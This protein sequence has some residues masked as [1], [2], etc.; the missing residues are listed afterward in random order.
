MEYTEAYLYTLIGKP[1]SV[2]NE[3]RRAIWISVDAG[4]KMFTISGFVD[5]TI[6]DVLNEFRLVE[7]DGEGHPQR[8]QI[9]GVWRHVQ[10]LPD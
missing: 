2:D 6:P 10:P 7:Q 3:Y 9:D 4:W 5:S 1:I 8:V